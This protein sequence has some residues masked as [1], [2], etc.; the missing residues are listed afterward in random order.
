MDGKE[1][2]K[3]VLSQIK[4]IES[5]I[6]R[7]KEFI[8]IDY[9]KIDLNVDTISNFN[10]LMLKIISSEGL[11]KEAMKETDILKTFTKA[12][13]SLVNNKKEKNDGKFDMNV[14]TNSLNNSN[15]YSKDISNNI[16]VN[17][18]D[19]KYDIVDLYKDEESGKNK[20]KIIDK[21]NEIESNIHNKNNQLINEKS[22]LSGYN[23]AFNLDQNENNNNNFDTSS[24]GYHHFL[25]EMERLK[26][27]LINTKISYNS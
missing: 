13:F 25:K 16:R 5:Y 14:E 3:N 9:Y 18:K 22:C 27:K 10:S 19:I 6:A 24:I 7:I 11:L 23:D 12:T 21:M 4:S 8:E 20:E 17:N 1:F 15:Y 2:Q 26:L